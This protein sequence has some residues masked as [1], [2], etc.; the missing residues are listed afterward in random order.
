[1]LTSLSL[2][3]KHLKVV[4]KGRSLDSFAEPINVGWVLEFDGCLHGIG[5]RIIRSSVDGLAHEVGCY[6]DDGCLTDFNI[7]GSDG[8]PDTSY[9][10]HMELLSLSMGLLSLASTGARGVAIKIIGDSVSI[11]TWTVEGKYNSE[12]AISAALILVADGLISAFERLSTSPPRRT[13]S[14][15]LAQE[16]L[17]L[18][19]WRDTFPSLPPRVNSRI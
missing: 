11:L 12:H 14:V 15:M 3:L 18:W 8:K 13:E 6:R 19:I 5:A 17:I 1:M 10:N 7:R 4:E 16:V 2:K 9:Q